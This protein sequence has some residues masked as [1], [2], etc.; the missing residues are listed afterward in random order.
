MSIALDELINYYWTKTEKMILE[1]SEITPMIFGLK[2]NLS[3]ASHPID[4]SLNLS[5]YDW[6]SPDDRFDLYYR[7][8]KAKKTMGLDGIMSIFESWV[9]TLDVKE[10]LNMGLSPD[11]IQ[12]QEDFL[13]LRDKYPMLFTKSESLSIYIDWCGETKL[14]WGRIF[15]VADKSDGRVVHVSEF[16]EHNEAS[17]DGI[18]KEAKEKAYSEP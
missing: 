2:E 1:N 10:M 9:T 15:R 6:G 16:V 18:I 13:D 3:G 12:T 11:G 17:M 14:V 4:L 7:A 8:F 5:F